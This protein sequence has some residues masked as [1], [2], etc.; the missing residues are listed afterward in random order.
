MPDMNEKEYSK[1]F[2]AFGDK[3]RLKILELLASGE[4]TVNEIVAAVGLSQP[5]VSRHLGVLR[6]AEVVVDRREG[7][8]VFYSLNKKVVRSCCEGFC[9]CLKIQRV[10]EKKKIRKK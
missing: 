9:C 1:Y 7:Q 6:D 10:S 8:N 4:M 2:K 3:S 5:T